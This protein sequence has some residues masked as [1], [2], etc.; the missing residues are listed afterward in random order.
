[1]IWLHGRYVDYVTSGIA[2]LLRP[3]IATW[4]YNKYGD[5]VTWFATS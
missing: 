3:T 2:E 5:Y 4:Q 1:M